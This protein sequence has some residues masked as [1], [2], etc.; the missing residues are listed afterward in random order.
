MTDRIKPA[1]QKR[2][3]VSQVARKRSMQDGYSTVIKDDMGKI[4]FSGI[5][6]IKPLPKQGND[7]VFKD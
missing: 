5:S 1:Q 4:I 6:Y 3:N 7:I 2:S